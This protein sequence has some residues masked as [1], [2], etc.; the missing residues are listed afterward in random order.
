MTSLAVAKAFADML[1]TG[2]HHGASERFNPPNIVSIEAIDGPM[3][4]LQS[5]PRDGWADNHE[6]T[7]GVTMGSSIN[8]DP[9]AVRFSIDV[10]NQGPRRDHAHGRGRPLP[11]QGRWTRRREAHALTRNAIPA[12]SRD[13]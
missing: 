9:F 4:R 10:K 2:D 11:D 12:K 3:A 13:G 8:G 5:P 1:R 6:L 7:S